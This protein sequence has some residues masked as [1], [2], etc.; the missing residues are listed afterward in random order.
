MNEFCYNINNNFKVY[1][2]ELEIGGERERVDSN[3]DYWKGFL[4]IA[5]FVK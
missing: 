3:V 1:S 4:K 2:S 5:T